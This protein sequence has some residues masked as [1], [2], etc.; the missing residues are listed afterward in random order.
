M[1]INDLVML[2][3]T[4]TLHH[5][6]EARVPRRSRSEIHRHLRDVFNVPIKQQAWKRAHQLIF[7]WHNRFIKL[8]DWLDETIETPQEDKE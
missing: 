2:E 5:N 3:T 1:Q 7:E 4:E 8:A 6:V